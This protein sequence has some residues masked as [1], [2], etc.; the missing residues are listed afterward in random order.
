M[1]AEALLNC[2]RWLMGPE[3]FWKPQEERPK[4]PMSLG[5]VSVGD[6]EVKADKKVCMTS[7]SANKV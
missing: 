2:E 3:F 6:L 5:D 7:G 4:A 1:S